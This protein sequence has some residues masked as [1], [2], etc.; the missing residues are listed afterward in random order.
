MYYYYY[1]QLFSLIIMFCSVYSVL[2]CLSVYCLCVN[3]YFTTATGCR[4]KL[5]LTKYIDINIYRFYTAK[6]FP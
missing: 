1:F 3:V 5:Q 4:T 2:I 6:N